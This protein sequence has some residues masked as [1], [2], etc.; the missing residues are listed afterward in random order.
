[1]KTLI[2]I[3][4]LTTTTL[5]AAKPC[6]KDY[7]TKSINQLMETLRKRLPKEAV[8]PKK[9]APALI[10]LSEKHNVPV[11]LL[12]SVM[13][14]ESAG[15]AEAF[16]GETVDHGIM[17]VNDASIRNYK[18]DKSQIKNW[19]Y[20]LESGTVILADLMKYKGFRPCFYNLGPK[21]KLAKY[22]KT[23]DNYERKLKKELI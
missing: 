21:G 9:L 11:K 23:C 3:L 16:N 19:R 17:Q 7:R 2:L 8:P 14:V 18:L 13:M 6:K 5:D 12:V 1:M 10:R 20:N 22:K 4:L 15:I